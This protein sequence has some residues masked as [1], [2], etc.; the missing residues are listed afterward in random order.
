MFEC[1]HFCSLQ[2][3]H[4]V[5]VHK[6]CDMLNEGNILSLQSDSDFDKQEKLY[7]PKRIDFTPV[8]P[9]PSPTRGFG[10]VGYCWPD[11]NCLLHSKLFILKYIYTQVNSTHLQSLHRFEEA[12]KIYGSELGKCPVYEALASLYCFCHVS[13][14][15]FK[16]NKRKASL[17]NWSAVTVLIVHVLSL[18]V[19][20]AI[21]ANVRE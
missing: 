8:S 10:K 6:I 20:V 9:A 15:P 5:V 7:S 2:Y 13:K 11:I 1:V 4:V 12:M 19:F 14:E 18:A 3:R 21:L 17:G 16:N